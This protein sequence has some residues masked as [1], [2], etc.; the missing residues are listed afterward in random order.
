MTSQLFMVRHLKQVRRAIKCKWK[1]NA[2]V[3]KKS[4]MSAL[5]G[6][7]CDSLLMYL[8]AVPIINRA[9]HIYL[10]IHIHIYLIWLT[11]AQ[12]HNVVGL[13]GGRTDAQLVDGQQ[14]EAVDGERSEARHLIWSRIGSGIDARHLIPD[15][16]LALAADQRENRIQYKISNI[17]IY[18]NL[19][20]RIIH[21]PKTVLIFIA[22]ASI[23]T[24]K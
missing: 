19:F 11:F 9:M 16:I 18:Y 15:A 12:R 13:L 20:I 24:C 17:P 2:I 3:K 6:N 4:V 14:T 5:S 10:Y 22:L 23:D 1:I 8:Y 7:L 21:M